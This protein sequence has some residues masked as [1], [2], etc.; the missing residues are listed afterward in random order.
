MEIEVQ[1]MTVDFINIKDIIGKII[2]TKMVIQQKLARLKEIHG[3]F[4]K[5][6]NTK[7]I[8]LIC[9]E[10]FHFQ[11]KVMN[12]DT[13]NIHR[14][15]MLLSNRTYC[16]YFNLYSM[17][18][19]VFGEYEMEVPTAQHHPAYKDL[20]PFFEYKLEEISLVHANAIELLSILI[21][22]LREKESLVQ[23]YISKSQ[24]GIRIANFIN[25]LE[26]ENSVLKDKIHLYTGYCDFFQNSQQKY[27]A[28]LYSKIQM[29]RDEI[30]EEISFHETPWDNTSITE[31][32]TLVQTSQD[33]A[34]SQW[35]GDE[36]DQDDKVIASR[37]DEA[38]LVGV[39]GDDYKEEEKPFIK[40]I[41]KKQ[42]KNNKH[43]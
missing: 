5:D 29:L 35:G 12:V 1:R 11:Y 33:L 32:D 39:S 15:F 40:Q 38:E 19:R 8:F 3:D 23:K 18:H 24:S 4:I 6:N 10:S 28:K 25:T 30:D 22:K 43:R 27:F 16:D 37:E 2:E 13:D 26:Y 9:L 17:L 14:S 31:K 20:E 42:N 41:N 21:L 34:V 7:K 36:V